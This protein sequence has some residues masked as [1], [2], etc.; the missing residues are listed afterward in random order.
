MVVLSEAFSVANRAAEEPRQ[1]KRPIPMS[2]R[3]AQELVLASVFS[4]AAC[5]D[6]TAEVSDRIFATDAS[7]ARG[8][9]CSCSVPTPV[10]RSLWQNGD[11]RGAYPRLEAGPRLLLKAAGLAPEEEDLADDFRPPGLQSSALPN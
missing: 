2:R 6:L 1:S 8:A 7:L 4:V 9:A 5:A 10:A 11:R 3:L